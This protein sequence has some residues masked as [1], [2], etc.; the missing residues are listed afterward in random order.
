[1]QQHGLVGARPRGVARSSRGGFT[2][3]EILVVLAVIALLVAI[4]LPALSAARRAGQLAS[5][6]GNLRQIATFMGLYQSDNED[7]IVPSQFNYTYPDCPT[8]YRGKVRSV[9]GPESYGVAH[10]GTWV[11]ILWTEAGIRPPQLLDATQDLYLYEAPDRAFYETYGNWEGNPFRS[12]VPNSRVHP[13]AEAGSPPLPYDPAGYGADD[14]GAPGYFAANNF[15]NAD[16]QSATFTAF[17]EGSRNGLV[18]L[19]QIRQASRA[20]Y[21]VDSWAG[22]VIEPA[23]E[24]FDNVTPISPGGG[25][26]RCQVDFRYSDSCIMLFLDGSSRPLS[27]WTNLTELESAASGRQVRVRNLTSR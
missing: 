5:S 20:M 9:L 7:T 13:Q 11:D 18:S 27:S 3:V 19:A 24:P 22:L 15:F 8:C 14:V 12:V 26:T 21:V 10:R 17:P 23:P 1:M 4:L 25:I 2:L 6:Q 16:E